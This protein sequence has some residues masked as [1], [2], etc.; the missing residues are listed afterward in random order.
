ME[1]QYVLIDTNLLVAVADGFDLFGQLEQEFPH[2][3]PTI[4][5]GTLNELKTLQNE[6]TGAE[7]RAAKLAQELVT[8]QHLNIVPQSVNHVDDALLAL[9]LKTGSVI[10]TQDKALQR[11]A[12]RE[13]VHVLAM[14]KK[15]LLREVP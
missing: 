15:H 11:R 5:E 8:R 12:R 3:T 1:R 7:K 4:V 9:A 13:R 10:A 2:L 14:R 6:G